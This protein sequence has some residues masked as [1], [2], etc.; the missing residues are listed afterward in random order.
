M[1]RSERPS[2][3]VPIKQVDV[4]TEVRRS[5]EGLID[6]GAYE[7]GD[8]LPGERQLSTDLGISRMAVREAMKVLEYMGRVEIRHGSGTFVKAVG[9]DPLVQHLLGDREID[10][11]FISELVDAR[12]AIEEALVR[13]AVDNL[14]DEAAAGLARVLERNEREQLEDLEVGSLNLLFE[15]RIAGIADSAILASLQRAIHEVWVIALGQLGLS[16]GHKDRLH[17][18]HL[19]IYEAMVAHDVDTATELMTNHVRSVRP[20][21][22]PEEQE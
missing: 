22:V 19:E 1:S 9:G 12:A 16:P 17:Q 11:A 8:K 5:L 20:G 14:D 15:Q 3:L 21:M 18:E 10:E 2:G 7:P 4:Y 6:N 13:A